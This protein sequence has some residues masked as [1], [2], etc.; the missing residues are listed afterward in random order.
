MSALLRRYWVVL[1][2]V[3]VFLVVFAVLLP[4]SLAKDTSR[5]HSTYRKNR[6]GC[7]ALADLVESVEP[8]LQVV[9]VRHALT[10]LEEVGGLLVI[11]DPERPFEDGEIESLAEWVEAGGRAVIAIEGPWD[12]FA[13]SRTGAGMAQLDIA[14]AFGLMFRDRPAVSREATPVPGSPLGSGVESVEIRSRY[15]IVAPD[16]GQDEDD[17]SDHEAGMVARIGPDD[18][19]RHLTAGDA[20]VMVSFEHGDGEIFLSADAEMFANGRLG[21]RDNLRFVA[22]LVWLNAPGGTVYFDEYHHG[23]KDPSRGSSGVDAAPLNRS[24]WVVALGA[25]LYLFGRGVRFG[26]PVPVFDPKRRTAMEYVEALA[27]LFGRA[28]AEQWALQKIAATFRHRLAA[29]GGMASAAPAEALATV[30]SRDRR[31]PDEECMA[32]LEQ[33]DALAVGGLPLKR[34]QLD[35]LAGRIAAVEERL[36]AQIKRKP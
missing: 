21:E 15:G 9:R 10:D 2:I 30:V 1:A 3:G 26:R 28:E 18:L 5:D 6:W 17:E 23:Y 27:D 7:A 25:A 33:V 19:T 24:L 22:N 35:A 31:M 14:Q 34:R 29:A 20:D 36:P 12:D 8:A 11:L 13:A 32:L 4:I 16:A